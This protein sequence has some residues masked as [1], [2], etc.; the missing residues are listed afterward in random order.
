[1][2]YEAFPGARD[3]SSD[4]AKTLRLWGISREDLHSRTQ[5]IWAKGFRPASAAT[6]AATEA[7]GS[8]FDTADQEQS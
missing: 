5:A 3:L 8:S 4:L 7:V 1:M 6:E 2:R